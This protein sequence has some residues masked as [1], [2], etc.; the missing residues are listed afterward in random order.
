MPLEM[1]PPPNGIAPPPR[2]CTKKPSKMCVVGLDRV[3][4]GRQL[5]RRLRLADR[6][7]A[8]RA[9]GRR[10]RRPVAARERARR[11]ARTCRARTGRR[12]GAA[13]RSAPGRCRAARPTGSPP[14]ATTP[15]PPDTPICCADTPTHAKPLRVISLAAEEKSGGVSE[16][17]LTFSHSTSTVPLK[18]AARGPAHDDAGAVRRLVV[19]RDR[20]LAVRSLRADG[21]ERLRGARREVLR[22]R[23]SP[24]VSGRRE[25][26]T[27]TT[28]RCRR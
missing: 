21:L 27:T 26:P 7:D 15:V 24:P 5:E 22:S 25:S 9:S 13:S 17:A 6:D 20:P 14:T 8:L 23:C 1:L 18:C 11:S 28:C 4:V 12:G 19:G 2:L 3:D 16:P 10:A